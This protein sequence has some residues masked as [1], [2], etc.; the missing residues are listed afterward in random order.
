MKIGPEVNVQSLV[1][2]LSENKIRAFE[3]IREALSNAKDHG[4][5]NIHVRISQAQRNEVSVLLVDDGEGMTD[6][7]LAAF[8]GIGAIE[9]PAGVKT[10]GYKGHGTKLY[11]G[12][13][14]L[15][16]ATRT[17]DTRWRVMSKEKPSER[18]TDA[19]EVRDMTAAAPLWKDIQNCG[20]AERR[21]T[22]IL[23]EHLLFTDA[24][25]LLGRRALES[26]CDWFTVIG[27]IR[28]GLFDSRKA[29]H[30]AV[31]AGG[32][33]LEALRPHEGELRPMTVHVQANG[34][35]DFHPLGFGRTASDK[36]FLAKWNEDVS[37]HKALPGLVAFGHRFADKHE[38]RGSQA[39]RVRDELSAIPL[40]SP[41]DWVTEDGIAIVARVEGHRRQQETY[42][43]AGWQNKPGLYTFEDRF[44]LW[45]CRD[46][47]PVV[48]RNDLLR[49]A[50]D[51]ASRG[52]RHFDFS[53]LRN[54]QVFLNDQ[55]FLP[56]ANRDDVSNQSEREPRFLKALVG[57]LARAMKQ[58]GF[59]SWV[60]RL[61]RAR[62]ERNRGREVEQMNERRSGVEDWINSKTKKDAIDPMTVQGLAKLDEES[63][64]LLRAP[65]S[66]QEL[67]HVYGLLSAR[68]EMPVQVLEYDATQGVDAIG[69]LSDPKLAMPPAVHG[70]VEF[71]HVVSANNPIDHY[72]DAIDVI[73]CWRVEKVGQVYEESSSGETIGTLSRRAKSLL[74]SRMDTHEITYESGGGRRVIP[75]LQVSTLFPA[76][77]ARRS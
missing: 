28:S 74:A 36:E 30:A 26:Y 53:S 12:S 8:W 41:A 16:V 42:V 5:R 52:S 19:V 25:E 68:Y 64:L 59:L 37:A 38:T 65:T 56:T 70:R 71:K 10:I 15:S 54:W 29:F 73:I 51:E 7:G 77:A 3:L 14:R 46:F 60:D 58:P 72:F 50:L 27:D 31:K 39:S 21:G 40:T 47:V 48:Q 57:V 67:F 11:F 20:L 33:E 32:A 43:E 1:R 69:R 6:R 4:A 55:Q 63:S 35:S 62:H 45:L 18:P 13:R 34:E 61:R 49:K 24:A 44:G 75:V 76:I 9:K 22:A 23:I 66:E 2:E 17:A